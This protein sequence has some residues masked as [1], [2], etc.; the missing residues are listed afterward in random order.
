MSKSWYNIEDLCLKIFGV[1]PNKHS[2]VFEY[3]NLSEKEFLFSDEEIKKIKNRIDLLKKDKKVI[4]IQSRFLSEIIPCKE[5]QKEIRP[6]KPRS[7]KF[8][9]GEI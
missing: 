2:I 7:I 8:I 5:D 9:T 6:K 4:A 3:N 1:L